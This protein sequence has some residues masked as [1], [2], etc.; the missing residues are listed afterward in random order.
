M[1]QTASQIENHIEGTREHLSS[2]LRELENKVKSVT[3]WRHQF[4]SRPLIF[5]GLALGGGV[6]AATAL[7]GRSSGPRHHH[8]YAPPAPPQGTEQQHSHLHVPEM[9]A[10]TLDK[11]SK[12][13]DT[14]AGALVGIAATRVK[15]YVEQ[16]LPGF[17]EQ[18]HRAESNR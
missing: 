10:P 14:F 18:Y 6:L 5:L 12:V 17:A 7:G 3:D 4:H 13:W 11:A 16:V 1:G 8:H 15:D 9:L 2:N